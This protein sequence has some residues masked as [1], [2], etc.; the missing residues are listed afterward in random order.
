[1]RS[2][3]A[4]GGENLRHEE[5]TEDDDY[6]AE[7]TIHTEWT[8]DCLDCDYTD[9]ITVEGHPHGGPPKEVGHAVGRHK[10]TTDA[11]HIVRVAGRRVSRDRSIDPS[12]VTDG[13]RDTVEAC[14][15]CDSGS[16][17]T[18]RPDH[19]NTCRDAPP[20]AYGCENC[21]AVFDDPV[22]RERYSTVQGPNH[23]LAGRLADPDVTDADDLATDGGQ[24]T[25]RE[26]HL[27]LAREDMRRIDG[28]WFHT[29]CAPDDQ[30]HDLEFRTDGGFTAHGQ[31]LDEL[32]D[33]QRDAI[34]IL[35]RDGPQYGLAIKRALQN[36]YGYDGIG[37]EV[38][39]GRLY[40]NLDTLVDIGLVAKSSLDQRTN[41]YELTERGTQFAREHAQ[42]WIGA[43]DGLDHADQGVP[44]QAVR[45]AGGDR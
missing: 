14:P 11:S 44:D 2:H 32:T 34:L 31:L 3:E 7:K 24:T 6:D 21:G 36:L 33:F 22:E 10:H 27:P 38:H 41:E 17:R 20:G 13:G 16:I 35:A 26:C 39:H 12:L 43:A 29:A 15:E 25:C 23:G 40:P 9:D 1:M 28:E 19:P 30:A 37:E 42:L 5:G 18:R 8:L 4:A 45:H